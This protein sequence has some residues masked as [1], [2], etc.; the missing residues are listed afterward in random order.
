MLNLLIPE[1]A[2]NKANNE[3]VPFHCNNRPYR[4]ILQSC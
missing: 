3:K 1:N 2:V 4:S